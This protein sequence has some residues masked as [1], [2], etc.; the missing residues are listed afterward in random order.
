VEGKDYAEEFIRLSDPKVKVQFLNTHIS[1]MVMSGVDRAEELVRE[2]L[3]HASS[4]DDELLYA[5]T[6]ISLANVFSEKAE[7]NE[8]LQI[9]LE[10][11]DQLLP[12]GSY[13]ALIRCY[14]AMGNSYIRT[15]DYDKGLEILLE[16]MKLSKQVNDISL[17]PSIYLN[18]GNLLFYKGKPESALEYYENSSRIAIE[19][20]DVSNE[21]NALNNRGAVFV[22][23][24]RFEEAE[25][26]L[27]QCT[28]RSRE[29]NNLT[30]VITSMDELAKVLIEQ[31][32]FTEAEEAMKEALAVADGTGSLTYSFEPMISLAEFYL[33]QNRLDEIEVYQKRMD[34]LLQKS[35][36]KYNQSRVHMLKAKIFESQKKYSEALEAYKL[37]HGLESEIWE[38]ESLEKLHRS[39]VSTLKKAHQRVTEISNIGR[40]ITETLDLHVIVKRVY[41]SLNN[42]ME[43]NIF[44]IASYDTE[45]GRISYEMFVEE[46]KEVPYYYTNVE[47]ETSLIAWCIREQDRVV[48][49]DFE[50]EHT[51]YVQSTLRLPAFDDNLMQKFPKSILV[52]PLSVEK[53]IVGAITIQSYKKNA[54]SEEDVSA[55]DILASYAAIGLNNALQ[56]QMIK[57]QN[58]K[59]SILATSDELT[60]LK[61]RRAFYE[62]LSRVWAWSFRTHIPLTLLMCD[63]DHFKHINDTYGHPCGD[64]CLKELGEIL[65]FCI[66]RSSDEV[67]RIG[68]EEFAVF[69]G[70]TEREGGGI[71]AERLRKA[72]EDH[73]FV[74]NGEEIE[75]TVSIGLETV[76]PGKD[77]DISI[78]TM[79][80]HADKALYQAKKSGRNCV[81]V[82]DLEN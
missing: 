23:L 12:L 11:R 37:H 41:E 29:T 73:N 13:H 61:N 74:Y 60:G 7:A 25:Q 40:A 38:Q 4:L 43:A 70:D 15:G 76:H 49:N 2:A 31:G 16:A 44:G 39:E 65:Q 64:Y 52:F 30:T 45:S 71:V 54:Y 82:F 79:F 14:S 35:I 58:K 63:I 34:E 5:E 36:S 50:N 42:F 75:V 77:G 20:G 8:A 59:L 33:S 32:K 17:Q 56:S 53:N 21:L 1:Q 9:L 72:I 48:I 24:K 10:A 57:D 28:Q 26:V 62:D 67:A 69:L 68:G 6:M 18:I 51:Q 3:I 55:M 78:E 19:A 66:Q 46:G 22:E 47:D 27:K 81:C 80:E